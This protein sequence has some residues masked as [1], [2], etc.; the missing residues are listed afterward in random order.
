MIKRPNNEERVINDFI[1][2]FLIRRDAKISLSHS[3]KTRSDMADRLIKSHFEIVNFN[4]LD[5]RHFLF[6]QSVRSLCS[7]GRALGSM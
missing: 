7:L 6:N 4:A 2:M 1:G 3:E 5:N